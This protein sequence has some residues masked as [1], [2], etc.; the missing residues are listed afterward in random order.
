MPR[1]TVAGTLMEVVAWKIVEGKG[2]V[3]RRE[4]RWIELTS[5]SEY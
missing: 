5:G 2:E 3:A 1:G 4:R